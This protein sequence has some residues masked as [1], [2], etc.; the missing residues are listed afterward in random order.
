ML[1][2]QDRYILELKEGKLSDLFL[3]KLFKIVGRVY[4]L[5]EYGC[6]DQLLYVVLSYIKSK[7]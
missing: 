3:I 4:G 7:I 1:F 2:E 6:E 5:A